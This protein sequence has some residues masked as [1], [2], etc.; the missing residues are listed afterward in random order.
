MKAY[1]ATFFLL[2]LLPTASD[3]FERFD[4]VTTEQLKEMLDARENHTSKDFLLVNTLDEIIY[5]NEHI[6]GSVNLPW[7]KI[8]EY[9]SVLGDNKDQQI[10]F[11]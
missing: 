2:F 11:Y 1:I 3:A 5:R 9:K 8:A 6:P 10:I 7:S 4:I